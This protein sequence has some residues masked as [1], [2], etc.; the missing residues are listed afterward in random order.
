MKH[1]ETILG[2]KLFSRRHGRYTPS[3]E[4]RDIFNQLN[5][6]YGKV[7]DLQYVIRRLAQGANSALRVGSVPSISNAMVPRAIEGVRRRFPDLLI[8]MDVL[9]FEEALDY[10]LLDKGEAVAMSSRFDHPM[11]TFEP[12]AKGRL[13]CIV[14]EGHPLARRNRIPAADI[15]RHPLIGIDPNDPTAASWPA[16]SGG[17]ASPTASP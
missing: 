3:P 15:V 4:A 11:P 12:L 17:S 1:A 6:V 5:A 16:S 14:P 7:G 10:L 2:L 8:D 13:F 9:K